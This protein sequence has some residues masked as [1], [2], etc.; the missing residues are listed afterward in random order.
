MKIQ[1]YYPKATVYWVIGTKTNNQG[2]LKRTHSPNT[3]V[4]LYLLKYHFLNH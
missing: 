2:G 3:Q 4:S 1:Q